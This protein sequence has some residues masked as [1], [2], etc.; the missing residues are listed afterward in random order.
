M[1]R[2]DITDHIGGQLFALIIFASFFTTMWLCG[3]ILP[4][5]FN[6]SEA[7]RSHLW[8]RLLS[9]FLLPLGAAIYIIASADRHTESFIIVNGTVFLL[10]LI[11]HYLKFSKGIKVA[12]G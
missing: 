10:I 9:F 2:P 5:F 7:V 11:F 3:T 4:V 12:E 6:L 8:S 1:L